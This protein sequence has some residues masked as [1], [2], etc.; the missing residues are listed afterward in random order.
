MS[1]WTR[2]SPPKFAPHAVP[3]IDGWVHPVTNEVLETFGDGTSNKPTPVASPTIQSCILYKSFVAASGDALPDLRTSFHPGDYLTFAVRFNAQ[4]TVV[5]A[6][7][8]PY[9]I[10]TIN[11]VQR[12][13][14]YV[15]ASFGLNCATL[16]FVYQLQASDAA[17]PGNI[18]VDSQLHL[19]G[20]I[21]KLGTTTPVTLTGIPRTLLLSLSAV[22]GHFAINNAVSC[23]V[24]TSLGYVVGYT[25]S[26]STSGTLIVVE[27]AGTF[28]TS[29][30]AG[31]QDTTTGAF[32]IL[33][34]TNTQLSDITIST[35]TPPVILSVA[36]TNG[37][38][39]V[40]GGTNGSNGT[41]GITATFDRP[42]SFTPGTSGTT[43]IKVLLNGTS[44]RFASAGSSGN[45]STLVF[46]YVIA[47][48]D[49]AG[50]GGVAVVSPILLNG[51]STIK[52]AS[53]NSVTPVSFTPPNTN[54]DQF[55]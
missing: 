9:I 1:L 16:L 6:T 54:T 14:A 11:G 32:G 50:T 46:N 13:A 10:V 23:G 8:S 41:F 55:N 45:S 36:A 49:T 38:T 31:L 19:S 21:Y 26:S 2:T 52:D 40:T 18:S 3:G 27:S 48:G 51:G 43:G 12:N 29:G 4:V 15:Q 20:H 22:T 42:V 47:S 53:G 39:F 25:P 35:T 44:A 37:V 5:P 24:N 17:T 33:N 34:A 30:T 7:G 28:T